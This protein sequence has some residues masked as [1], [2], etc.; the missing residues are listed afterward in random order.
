MVT[1]DSALEAFPVKPMGIRQAI[2]MALK[3]EDDEVM[4]MHWAQWS[5]SRQFRNYLID[6]RT[7]MV[8][9][10]VEQAFTAIE[11]IGGKNGWYF[12][13]WLWTLR[14][15][16]DRL[17]GGVGMRRA[18]THDTTLREGDFLDFWR[19]EKVKKNEALVLRAEMKVPGRAWL[20]WEFDPQ[21]NGMTRICQTAIFDPLG[22]PGLGYWFLVTP[23]H[24]YVFAGLLNRI[25]RFKISSPSV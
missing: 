25:A 8:N 20:K 18:R 19:I 23:L 12:A 4:D 2:R 6:S 10:P 11:R 14:G 9:K 24:D 21:P 7:I 1:D 15:W 17:V 22:M 3:K 16:L 5:G 13:D